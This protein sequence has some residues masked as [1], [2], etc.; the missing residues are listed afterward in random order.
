METCQFHWQN[1]T[2]ATLGTDF[3]KNH[4]MAAMSIVKLEKASGKQPSANCLPEDRNISR[5]LKK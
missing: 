4:K 1:G 3:A 2:P 5:K